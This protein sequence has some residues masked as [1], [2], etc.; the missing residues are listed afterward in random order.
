[1]DVGRSEKDVVKV[2]PIVTYL[3]HKVSTLRQ[4]AVQSKQI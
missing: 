4:R 2:I 3:F 1:V